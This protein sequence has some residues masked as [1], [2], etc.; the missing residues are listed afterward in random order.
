METTYDDVRKEA[1][2][3]G[4]QTIYS[5]HKSNQCLGDFCPVH[6]P[7]DHDLRGFDLHFNF[8]A[9]SFFR[10]VVG[11]MVVDPDDYVLNETGQVIVI[12]LISCN[13][14]GDLVA[15]THRHDFH[16]CSCGTVAADGGSSYLRRMGSPGD[17]KEL[18]VIVRK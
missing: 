3:S 16:Q 7:S 4:G 12:N 18:S 9:G 2:L 15:S 5:F 6:N 1:V 10:D 14:C 11:E 8:M 13:H 17:Y